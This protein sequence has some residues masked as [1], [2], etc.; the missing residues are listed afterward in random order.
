[1]CYVQLPAESSAY[2][3]LSLCDALW[4]LFAE[5]L[6]RLSHADRHS[7]QLVL[8]SLSRKDTPALAD[9]LQGTGLGECVL[10]QCR[11]AAASSGCLLDTAQ[12]CACFDELRLSRHTSLP[13]QAKRPCRLDAAPDHRL[14]R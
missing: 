11:S 6:T 9:T 1:M 5:A 3:H 14:Q 10:L 13:A 8:S 7:A 12:S 2:A 4:L